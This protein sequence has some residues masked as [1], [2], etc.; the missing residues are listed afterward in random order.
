MS[1][2]T[3]E[4]LPEEKKKLILETGI[5][6]FSRKTYK[7]SNTD[8]ITKA[9]GI[10][11]GILFHYFGSKKEFYLYCL[12]KA[13]EQLTECTSE[14]TEGNFYDIIF[15]SMNKRIA[16]CMKY[17]DEMHMVNMAC[18][19]ASIEIAE[20]KK[21]ILQKYLYKGKEASRQTIQRA[22]LTLE[23]KDGMEMQRLAEGVS[24]YIN[25]VLDKY[26]VMYQQMPD[27]FF[28]NSEKIKAE[29]KYY[30][31]MLLYGICKN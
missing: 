2:E 8:L 27:A 12:K 31:D 16:L 17:S 14:K 9:C 5:K 21:S 25:A 28:E 4:K 23:L 19:D 7:D 6:E 11:K 15:G 20:G 29:I 18:K 13:L 1:I 10:S 26:L 30:L 22:L 3:F 24:M